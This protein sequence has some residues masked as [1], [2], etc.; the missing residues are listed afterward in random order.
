MEKATIY[1]AIS[2]PTALVGGL[3]SIFVAAALSAAFPRDAEPVARLRLVFLAGWLSVLAVT[4]AAN[5]WFLWRDAR[6]RGDVFL[7]AGMRAAVRAFSPS[8]L[9]AAFLT[10]FLANAPEVLPPVWMLFYGLGLLATQH[11][12]P[13]S[14]SLLGWAFL[15]ASLYL[16]I[17]GSAISTETVEYLRRANF[18]MGGTF[19]LFHLIYAGFAWPREKATSPAG[20]RP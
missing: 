11:F 10:A 16:G 1:R 12:A 17:T 2:A 15:A 13:R 7:S 19:G 14:I 6:R 4:A 3:A 8:Y 5:T 18:A 9:V 20:G